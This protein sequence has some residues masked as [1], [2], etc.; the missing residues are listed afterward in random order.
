LNEA[1]GAKRVDQLNAAISEAIAAGLETVDDGLDIGLVELADAKTVLASLQA[2]LAALAELEAAM[3]AA[4]KAR[5]NAAIQAAKETSVQADHPDKVA[6]AERCVAAVTEL[7]NS[8]VEAK[9]ADDK[10][11]FALETARD[12]LVKAIK[13]MRDAGYGDSVKILQDAEVIRRKVHN[14]LQDLIGATRVFC[15]VRPPNAREKKLDSPV[16]VHVVGA[17]SVECHHEEGATD[18]FEFD[19]AFG[20]DSTQE[21]VFAECKDLVQSVLD[22]YNVTIFAYGQTGA[23]KTWTMMGSDASPELLGVCP[24]T[25]SCLFEAIDRNSQRYDIKVKSFMVEV[26]CSKINDLGGAGQRRESNASTDSWECKPQG[27]KKEGVKLRCIGDKVTMEGVHE[28]EISKADDLFQ[29]LED[30]NSSKKVTATA[31]NAGSS[32]S[33]T[34]LGIMIQCTNKET[35]NTHS[36]KILLVDLAGSERLKKSEVTGEARKE[37]I[38]INKSLT[39]LGDVISAIT[40][41]KRVPYR[42]HNLTLLMSDSLGGTAKTLMFVNASP[43]LDNVDETAMAL[44]FATRTKTITKREASIVALQAARRGMIDRRKTAELKNPVEE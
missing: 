11:P 5:I 21:Q 8:F 25:I 7:E 26:Y 4:D 24:R 34:V 43:A 33:H 23:G 38:E 1:V 22:G 31:M 20:P 39:A 10:D 32:R 13:E 36:G 3:D 30:G 14:T 6:A 27:K 2:A 44:A 42:N 9:A 41:H 35:G 17:M 15:R 18:R 19:A 40:L 29:L 12:S 16:A 37:A 28:R